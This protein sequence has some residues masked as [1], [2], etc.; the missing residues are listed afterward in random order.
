MIIMVRDYSQVIEWIS[1]NYS[2]ADFGISE[3]ELKEKLLTEPRY[4]FDE[5]TNIIKQKLHDENSPNFSYKLLNALPKR[6]VYNKLIS[7]DLDRIKLEATSEKEI[8][9]R[10]FR[11]EEMRIAKQIAD[12]EE[13]RRIRELRKLQAEIANKR[14]EEMIERGE[15]PEF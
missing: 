10:Q 14:K 11:A 2:P 6:E 5:E 12:D 15:R 13:K 7:S 4:S 3:D 9:A 8:Q 1:K